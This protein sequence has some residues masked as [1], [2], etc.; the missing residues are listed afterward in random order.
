MLHPHVWLCQLS[1]TPYTGTHGAQLAQPS[2]AM[3]LVVQPTVGSAMAHVK[4]LVG[5]VARMDSST[6]NDT[7]GSSATSAC[8]VAEGDMGVIAGGAVRLDHLP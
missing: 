4:A 1:A 2:V 7:L 5:E 3:K 6:C 8:D